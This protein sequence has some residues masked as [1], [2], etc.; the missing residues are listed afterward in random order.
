MGSHCGM[1]PVVARIRLS[2]GAESGIGTGRAHLLEQEGEHVVVPARAGEPG[3]P[4][5]QVVRP[6]TSG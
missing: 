4:V 5:Q 6:S 3:R 2:V 1:R